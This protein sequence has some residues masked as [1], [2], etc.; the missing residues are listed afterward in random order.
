MYFEQRRFCFFSGGLSFSYASPKPQYAGPD[1]TISVGLT[2]A[3]LSGSGTTNIGSTGLAK[4]DQ[5]RDS[6]QPSANKPAPW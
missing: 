4:S 1:L 3:E 5:T 2:G 6:T